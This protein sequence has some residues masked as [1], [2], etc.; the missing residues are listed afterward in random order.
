M[1][2][3]LTKTV[4]GLILIIAGC[5]LLQSQNEVKLWTAHS[6]ST[7]VS[8]KWRIR[9]GQLYLFDE[10]VSL[11]SLQNSARLEY[12]LDKKFRLGLGYTRSSDPADVDQTAKNR[13]ETRFR[14]R[15][16]WGKL[17]IYNYLRGEWH[18]PE[19]SKFEYRIRYALGLHAGD[20][21]MPL[22]ITPYI[23]NEL[24]YY[25]N[26]RPFQYRDGNGEKLV[27][28]SPDGLHAY[29]IRLGVRF[30]PFKRASASLSFM[31][32]TEFNIGSPFRRLNVTD[33]RNGEIKRSFNNFSVLAF[34]FSYRFK[35]RSRS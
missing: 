22:R 16:R 29:R 11:S 28:Q 5:N 18:F 2:Y 15:V 23:T 19:R 1:K 9:A 32:Q 12:R 21:G 24:H 10:N 4:L 17:R 33:P 25:L 34:S 14:Y 20:W 27:K 26:G 6:Y 35:I 8:D 3:L 31:R 30:R 13:V 7:K